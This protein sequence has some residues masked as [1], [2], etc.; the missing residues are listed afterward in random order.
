MAI[1]GGAFV[2]YL[3]TK[4]SNPAYAKIGDCVQ[5]QGSTVKVVS[6][7]DADA[8]YRVIGRFSG[9][10]T[11]RCQ[12]VTGTTMTFGGTTGSRRHRSHY[13]LCLTRN[14]PGSTAP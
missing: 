3:F 1:L 14:R 13:V 7:T 9:S 6:C 12:E 10:L 2:L 4:G 5:H 8:E 11:S